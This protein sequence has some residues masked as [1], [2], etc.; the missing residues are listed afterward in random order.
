MAELTVEDLHKALH[1]LREEIREARGT[2]K[3]LRYEIKTARELV[4]ATRQLA[5]EVAET[6]VRD[7]L[8]AEVSRQLSALNEVTEQQMSKSTAKV[9]AEFDK[10]HDLL[11]GHGKAADGRGGHSI[12]DLLQDPAVL[13][14]ARRAVRQNTAADRG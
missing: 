7:L 2:L 3:D 12:P 10:L 14:R 13:A 1:Q 5:A 4:E 8:H 6:Q 9:I 11:L